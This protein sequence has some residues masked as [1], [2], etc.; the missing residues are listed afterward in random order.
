AGVNM[1]NNT[2]PMLLAVVASPVTVVVG[3]AASYNLLTTLAFAASAGA[4]YVLIRRW[5]SWRP[6]A[7]VGGLLYGFS[8]YMVSVGW[9]HLF[10]TFVPW[11]PLMVL[12]LDEVLVRQRGSPIRWGLALGLLAIAQFFTS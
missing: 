3:A 5:T 12:C 9:A 11:L 8:P 7:F 4:A 6:A 1:L 10:L 2:T